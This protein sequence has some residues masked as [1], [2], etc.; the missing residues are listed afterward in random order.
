MDGVSLYVPCYNA[1]PWLE[2]CLE[3]IKQQTR[4][5]EEVIVVDDGSRDRTREIAERAGVRVLVHD[6]NRGLGAARNTAL[7]QARYDLVAALDADCVASPTWLAVLVSRMADPR[8]TGV[9]GLLVE[10]FCS[11]LAD[12][13]RAHHMRQHWGSSEQLEPRFLFGNNNLF[14]KPAL[15]A[16]GLYDENLRSNFEDVAM[17]EALL[18][19]GARLVYDPRAIVHHLRRDTV[20]SIIRGNWKWRFYGYRYPITVRGLLRSVVREQSRLL[21][22]FFG[23]DLQRRDPACAALTCAALGYSVIADL[24]YTVAHYGA[25]PTHLPR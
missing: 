23:D 22:G 16:A 19:R 13:W 17:S 12:R 24:R 1:E 11:S 2:R 3:G 14:R 9:G 4:P 8:T 21:V 7:R 18:G 15:F 10:T 25:P 20:P 5:P 6:S